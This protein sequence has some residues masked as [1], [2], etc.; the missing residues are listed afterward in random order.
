MGS[1]HVLQVGNVFGIFIVREGLHAK[2]IRLPCDGVLETN[3][4]SDMSKMELGCSC[5]GISYGRL[6]ILCVCIPCVEI[7]IL[8]VDSGEE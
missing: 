3:G 8:V 4:R 5:V 2:A 7:V 6:A 1:M